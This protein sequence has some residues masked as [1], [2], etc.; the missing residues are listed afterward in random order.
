MKGANFSCY[1]TWRGVPALEEV[2][3]QLS[4]DQKITN[5]LA[6]VGSIRNLISAHDAI[7][8]HCVNMGGGGMLEILGGIRGTELK[9]LS[10]AVI[11]NRFRF[12]PSGR[13]LV[14]IESGGSHYL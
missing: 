12:N 1:S 2:G 10:Q 5:I 14:P 9:G 7:K 8:A 11:G 6:R 4:N 3:F 13:F